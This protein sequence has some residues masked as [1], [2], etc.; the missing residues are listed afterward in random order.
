MSAEAHPAPKSYLDWSDKGEASL[1]RYCLGS[2]LVI[3][4]FFLLSGVGM[5][6]LVLL[7]PE[8]KKS[9]SLSVIATLLNFVVAFFAIPLIVR[10]VHKRP[11]WSVAMPRLR[12][13]SWNFLTG[14]WVGIAVAGL[15]AW[16][17]SAT[18]IMQLEQN[19][20][21]NLP[22]LL[23]L[24]VVGFVGIF[25]QAGSEEMLFR[26]YF[27]QFVRRF[28]SNRYLFI[29]LPALL[30]A[31]PHIANI[32]ALGGSAFVLIPYIFSGLLYGWAAFRFG[33]LWMSVSIHLVNNYTGLV[34]VGTKGDALRSAAP[35][36]IDVPGLPLATLV[37]LLQS[38]TMFLALSYIARRSGR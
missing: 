37:V 11:S 14:L 1:W 30:F 17:F 35:Y 12:F 8:Y 21:F 16:L 6:P 9:L 28:T 3:V 32:A 27:T 38:A 7:A 36:V 24:A 34:L 31:A 4:V 33:S 13:E 25:I 5:V 18:G 26:G 15:A 19:P 20:D 10:L 22:T 2:L 23:L 29:G